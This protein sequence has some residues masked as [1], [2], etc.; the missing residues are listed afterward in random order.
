LPHCAPGYLSRFVKPR[1]PLVAATPVQK[2]FGLRDS[3]VPT[4]LPPFTPRP[5]CLFHIRAHPSITHH[6]RHAFLHTLFPT[7]CHL[8][9]AA[10]PSP[11]R[12]PVYTPRHPAPYFFC[13]TFVTHGGC[14]T[15][16]VPACQHLLLPWL[17]YLLAFCLYV[18]LHSPVPVLV[19]P[20]GRAR[21]YSVDFKTPTPSPPRLRRRVAAM[22][23]VAGA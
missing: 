19:G 14:H 12:T 3:L 16:R 15:T 5:A 21:V 13:R 18:P 7:P 20:C 8:L 22:T 23:D 1:L 2:Q 9:P 4:T 10:Q 6:L 11:V 17:D